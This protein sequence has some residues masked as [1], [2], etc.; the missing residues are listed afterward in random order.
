MSIV[1]FILYYA[2]NK[3]KLK[4][5][6]YKI[7]VKTKIPS[8]DLEFYIEEEDKGLVHTGTNCTNEEFTKF[9]KPYKEKGLTKN[10]VWKLF[11]EDLRKN[12]IKCNTIFEM[13]DKF[14]DEV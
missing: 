10:E 3:N 1:D 12:N 5:I 14:W 8:I 11:M 13:I 9:L 7:I 6:F 2:F 4:V